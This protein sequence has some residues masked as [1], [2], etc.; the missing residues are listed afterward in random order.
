VDRGVKMAL[1]PAHKFGQMIGGILELAIE[2]FL[3]DFAQNYGLY[4]D[5]KGPRPARKGV[6]LSWKDRNGNKHDLDFVLEKNGSAV[7]QG[8]PAAFIEAAWRRHTKHSKNKAQEIQGAIDPLVETYKDYGPFFGAILAGEF[9]ETSLTQLRSLGFAVLYFHYEDVVNA[10]KTVD[11][12]AAY[13]EGMSDEEMAIKV[14]ATE[15]LSQEQRV[16]VAKALI[17][18]RPEEVAKFMK[19]LADAVTRQVELVLVVPLHGTVFNAKTVEEAIEFIETYDES[20]FQ[21]AFIRYEAEIRYV[22]GDTIKAVYQNKARI[23]EF[24]HIHLPAK[25]VIQEQLD[26]FDQN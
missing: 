8:A 23:I 21:K 3:R 2:P 14:L 9:T 4:L 6:K 16:K 19:A 24:L 5:V 26:L 13:V 18:T 22:N 20:S 7:Q 1:S 17:E 12:D 11:I 25:S 10:F 15:A